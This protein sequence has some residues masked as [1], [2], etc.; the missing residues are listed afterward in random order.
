MRKLRVAVPAGIGD[1]SWIWSKLSTIKDA[2]WEFF[3]PD[4][5]PYR[6]KQYVD[7]LPNCKGSLGQHTY[8]DILFWGGHHSSKTWKELVNSYEEDDIIYLEANKHLEAGKPLADFL[9][10]LGTNYH[11]GFN[12]VDEPRLAYRYDNRP[13]L[14]F[15]MASIR[16]IR[17]W[18]AWMPETWAEFLV[19]FR[20]ANPD[21][22][23]VALGG[24]WD[25]D[26][27]Q[28]LKG[29]L[30]EDFPLIDLVGKTT[31]SEA[32]RILDEVDYY[33]GF[34]SG[35]N[36]IRNVLDKPCTALWPKHQVGLMYSHVDPRAINDRSYTG[37][38]YDTPERI[39][40]RIK[41]KIRSIVR[42][43]VAVCGSL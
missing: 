6:T 29:R 3:P 11:Y 34:S 40:L 17:A 25:I 41:P 23:F 30:P 12:L 35:L 1:F 43:E 10:D 26:T 37:Y 24:Q 20:K 36:V 19:M 18:N 4:A 8:P 15:H 14:G 16:G 13:V 39:Y 7:L 22:T 42:P 32:I 27:L 31:I 5:F 28:E 2:M 21:W 38:V 9:P 33:I